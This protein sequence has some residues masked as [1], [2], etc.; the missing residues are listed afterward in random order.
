MDKYQRCTHFKRDYI[1]VSS[2]MNLLFLSD[3]NKIRDK[4]IEVQFIRQLAKIS[5]FLSYNLVLV[6]YEHRNYIMIIFYYV[7]TSDYHEFDIGLN[8]CAVS[9]HQAQYM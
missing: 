8:T 2:E 6:D 4:F 5:F 3:E 7:I 9:Y 1:V